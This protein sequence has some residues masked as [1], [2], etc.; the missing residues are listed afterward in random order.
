MIKYLDYSVYTKEVPDELSLG[1]SIS[2]C[3]IQCKGCHST[4]TW[5]RNK[6][7][8]L[9]GN[10]LIRLFY[11]YHR[12]VSCLLFFGGEWDNSLIQI[13][14]TFKSRFNHKIALYTGCTLEEILNRSDKLINHLDYIK[15]GPYISKYGPINNLSTNQRMYK[16]INGKRKDITYKFHS[17]PIE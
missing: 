14:N 9:S 15:V 12:L 16:L 17:M 8:E 10:N 2:G 1:I 5:D 4:H 7:K 11:P 13:I 3:P 6:G